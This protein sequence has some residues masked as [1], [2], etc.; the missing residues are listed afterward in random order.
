MGLFDLQEG[1]ETVFYI[2][3]IASLILF[4]VFF[5]GS[6]TYTE[7]FIPWFNSHF[8]IDGWKLYIFGFEDG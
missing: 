3:I 8:K 4:V 1:F 6:K 7:I 5:T 2:L